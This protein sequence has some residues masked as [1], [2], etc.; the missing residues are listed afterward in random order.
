MLLK[1]ELESV[2]LSEEQLSTNQSA[3]LLASTNASDPPPCKHAPK[4][5]QREPRGLALVALDEEEVEVKEALERDAVLRKVPARTRGSR[6]M[7]TTR[8]LVW[9]NESAPFHK[10]L[11]THPRDFF[12]STFLTASMSAG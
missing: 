8:C 10:T 12:W 11:H 4:V 9:T 7:R 1:L 6:P 2:Y 3:A 5:P